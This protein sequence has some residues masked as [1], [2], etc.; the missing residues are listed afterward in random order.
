MSFPSSNSFE[1]R[2][3]LWRASE[4]WDHE[5]TRT[6]NS[7]DEISVKTEDPGCN[8]QGENLRLGI[9][10]KGQN[11]RNEPWTKYG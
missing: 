3:K 6:T 9:S 4:S 10:W 11:F 1:G 2:K 7:K 8:S 5:R